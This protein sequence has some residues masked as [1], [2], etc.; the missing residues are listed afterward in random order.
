M[1]ELIMKIEKT[2][3]RR[4]A[5]YVQYK[6]SRIT[7]TCSKSALESCL[8]T[9]SYCMSAKKTFVLFYYIIFS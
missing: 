6:G 7:A 8:C 2:L 4:K 5:E 1:N 3:V 9:R